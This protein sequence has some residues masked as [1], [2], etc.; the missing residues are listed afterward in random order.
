MKYVGIVIVYHDVDVCFICVGIPK[1]SV[2]PTRD[3]VFLI[4]ASG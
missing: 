1:I 3:L 4:T 2:S